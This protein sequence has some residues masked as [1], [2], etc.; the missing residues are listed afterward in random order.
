MDST[1]FTDLGKI[2]MHSIELGKSEDYV[3]QVVRDAFANEFTATLKSRS[4]SFLAF[5]RW[6][7]TALDGPSS[8][9]F[10]VTEAM[11]YDY[12]HDLCR[13]NAAPSKGKRFLEALGF[14]KGLL[15]ADV[16]SILNSARVRGA[17]MAGKWNAVKKKAPLTV[18]Q[19]SAFSP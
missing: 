19:V 18:E 4:A 13:M 14:S 1:S 7:K 17:A 11:A 9:I 10:P 6:K 2:L 8:G 12:L 5:G 16:D 3:W 15:G